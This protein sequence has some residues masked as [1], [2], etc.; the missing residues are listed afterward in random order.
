M[1]SSSEEGS[2]AVEEWLVQ[3]GAAASVGLEVPVSEVPD[4]AA[5]ADHV[6]SEPEAWKPVAWAEPV[7]WGE[8]VA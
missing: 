7:A 3:G 5:L 2:L 8:P 6:A 1:A 4:R